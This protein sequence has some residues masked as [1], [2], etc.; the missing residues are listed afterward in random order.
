MEFAVLFFVVCAGLAAG[1][2]FEISRD[3][4]QLTKT[5]KKI[6]EKLDQLGSR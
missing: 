4:K 1:S 3:L 5:F 2:L 6:E